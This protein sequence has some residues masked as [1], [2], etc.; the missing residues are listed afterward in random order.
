[1]LV[2]DDEPHARQRR[3]LLPPLKGERMDHSL[4]LCRSQHWVSLFPAASRFG[5]SALCP[6]RRTPA[7]THNGKGRQCYRR[8]TGR[9]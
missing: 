7:P 5:R 1:M 2:L 9:V 4:T 6:H 8:S 3:I